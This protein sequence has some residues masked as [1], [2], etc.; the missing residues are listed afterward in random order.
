[1]L[2]RTV[3]IATPLLFLATF[4][5]FCYPLWTWSHSMTSCTLAYFGFLRSEKFT[6][7]SPSVFLKGCTCLMGMS[8]CTP[9]IFPTASLHQSLQHWP[10][11]SECYW[12]WISPS[13]RC[14]DSCVFPSPSWQP[15]WIFICNDGLP[16]TRSIVTVK[17]RASVGVSGN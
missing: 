14:A 3:S 7:P 1:M 6:V 4:F 10:R 16:L 12:L 13:L 11:G 17:L 15:P 2:S 9:G 5:R 8:Q